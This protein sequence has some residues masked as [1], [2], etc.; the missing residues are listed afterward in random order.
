MLQ[1]DQLQSQHGQTDDSWKFLQGDERQ[2]SITINLNDCQ[3]FNARDQGAETIQ[4]QHKDG[5]TFVLQVDSTR[6]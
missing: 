3:Q 4:L 6:D 5:R 1:L 2:Q